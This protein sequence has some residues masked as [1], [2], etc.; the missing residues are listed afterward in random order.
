MTSWNI[1]D[2]VTFTGFVLLVLTPLLCLGLYD[3]AVPDETGVAGGP[4]PVYKTMTTCD[5]P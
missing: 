2:T 3:A 5:N 4:C 1:A